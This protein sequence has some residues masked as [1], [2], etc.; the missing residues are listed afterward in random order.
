MFMIFVSV[1]STWHTRADVDDDSSMN[2][3]M[4]EDDTDE[5]YKYHVTD[6]H[7]G[8]SAPSD[9]QHH[10]PESPSTPI[11]SQNGSPPP[12]KKM[13]AK[14]KPS[15]PPVLPPCRVC[16]DRASGFHYGVNTC[17]ACKVRQVCFQHTKL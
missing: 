10:I 4:S 2:G 7:P 16:G 12:E 1:E 3:Y 15:R 13:R 17:E 8:Y 5:R 9:T 14:Y 11:T 6:V